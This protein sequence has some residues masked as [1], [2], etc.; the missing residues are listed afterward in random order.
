MS[1]PDIETSIERYIALSTAV[2]RYL[3][4]VESFE[5]VSNEFD[6]ACST[7]RDRLEKPSRF[8]IKVDYKYYLVTSDQDRNIEV[9]QLRQL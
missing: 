4:A 2:L 7:L 1:S 8:L 5:A 6:E 3:R 9:E